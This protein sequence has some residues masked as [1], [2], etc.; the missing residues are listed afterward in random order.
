MAN[1]PPEYLLPALLGIETTVLDARA[2]SP[3]MLDKD[4]EEVYE[5][6]KGFYQQ[7]AQDKDV[8][9]PRFH[10]KYKTGAHF[11]YY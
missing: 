5:D 7:L 3:K 10:E 11:G 2:L 6:L 8:F 9:E 1:T 4:V